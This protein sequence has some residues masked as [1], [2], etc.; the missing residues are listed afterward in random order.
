[1]IVSKRRIHGA[2]CADEVLAG[3]PGG[4]EELKNNFDGTMSYIPS[5]T[6]T[7]CY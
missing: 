5:T 7:D 4:I 6:Y 1:M 2:E 3:C